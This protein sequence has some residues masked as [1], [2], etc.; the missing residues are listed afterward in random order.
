[1]IMMSQP[2]YSMLT[3]TLDFHSDLVLEIG[4]VWKF[5]KIS[6]FTLPDFHAK[7]FL[8]PMHDHDKPSVAFFEEYFQIRNLNEL[9]SYC[10]LTSIFFLL[11]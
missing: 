4:S 10:S 2:S 7:I 11:L 9:F 6:R 1:M 5:Q 3:K 8:K